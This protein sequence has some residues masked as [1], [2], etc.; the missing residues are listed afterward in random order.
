MSLNTAKMFS[1]PQ[2]IAFLIDPTTTSDLEINSL[3]LFCMSV[4]GG[5]HFPIVP[6]SSINEMSG[7]WL[8]FLA[9]S[10]PDLV[11]STIKISDTFKAQI[12]ER[13]RPITLLNGDRNE[14]HFDSQFFEV[15]S[16]SDV[17]H[18][19]FRNF[20][21]QTWCPMLTAFDTLG[22]G[23]D[24]RR[25]SDNY[26]LRNFGFLP[27]DIWRKLE[28]DPLTFVERFQIE[29][30]NSMFDLYGYKVWPIDFCSWN[31]SRFQPDI[32][33]FSSHVQI[34][35]GD[36]LYE[37]LHWWNRG[38]VQRIPMPV[39]DTIWVP[40]EMLNGDELFFVELGKVIG[41]WTDL[42]GPA[43]FQLASYTETSH[44][45]EKI[46]RT[47]SESSGQRFQANNLRLEEFDPCQ[48]STS[49]GCAQDDM[50]FRT[51]ESKGT[52]INIP[53]PTDL[54]NT[55]KKKLG[56]IVEIE[57]QTPVLGNA[58]T[59]KS[60]RWHLPAREG[61]EKLFCK[62]ARC[63]INKSGHLVAEIPNLDSTQNLHLQIPDVPDLMNH[64]LKTASDNTATTTAHPSALTQSVDS[65][66]SHFD[67]IENYE[68]FTRQKGWQSIFDKLSS[69]EE[70]LKALF[71]SELREYF[72]EFFPNDLQS[73]ESAA[74]RLVSAY[75]REGHKQP[76][77]LT[78]KGLKDL[79]HKSQK[80][81]S[82]EQYE[83]E[84]SELLERRILFEGS[85]LTCTSCGIR[86][87][88]TVDQ[89]SRLV[90]CTSCLLQFNLPHNRKQSVRMN[91]LIYTALNRLYLRPVI[92]AISAIRQKTTESML[93]WPC[94]DLW[95]SESKLKITD[96]DL[97]V[98]ADSRTLFVE[99]K[100]NA[101]S[102]DKPNELLTFINYAK[103]AKPDEVVFAAPDHTFAPVD[104]A[105]FVNV[106]KELT[107]ENILATILRLT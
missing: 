4:W 82:E 61:L 47:L 76:H 78:L 33:F 6:V 29:N 7:D 62:N 85:E 36:S 65:V 12:R 69:V 92:A 80:V 64:I 14:F 3:L 97:L 11:Y 67:G 17:T 9:N 98:L 13:V 74:I 93:F 90:T 102:F 21:P 56:W 31:I 40:R 105:W 103:N 52:L 2:K 104:P 5:R 79:F 28:L 57:F 75:R 45:L 32:P 71:E 35:L 23:S 43:R 22:T 38:T 37:V 58:A 48:V 18:S 73:F 87:W 60:G 19:R 8:S 81:W 106:T 89:L 27:R 16:V 84:L 50:E 15:A 77:T 59:F 95:N 51:F 44:T 53:T 20:A 86:G 107:K 25:A 49:A 30:P 88:F 83:T 101:A 41:G 54:K 94:I 66:L 24:I 72:Q 42:L 100:S 1:R 55:N 34:I 10:E 63:K 26:A 39:R 46:A 96:I 91:G 99:V 70:E 68:R